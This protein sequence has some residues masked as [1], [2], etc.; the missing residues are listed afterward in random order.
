MGETEPDR[1][2]LA[3]KEVGKFGSFGVV[4]LCTGDLDGVIL[5]AECLTEE[6]LESRDGLAGRGGSEGSANG[7]VERWFIGEGSLIL[8]GI[9]ELDELSKPA[10]TT[11][12][13]TS[14]SIA[15]L[16][17]LSVGG[18]EEPFLK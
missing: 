10:P 8:V 5:P 7:L 17:A 9:L 6:L 11:F 18:T 15:L 3:E 12:C 16:V 4:G 2:E 14:R 1:D 13:N